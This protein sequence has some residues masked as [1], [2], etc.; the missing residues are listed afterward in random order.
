MHYSG[1]AALELDGRLRY[2]PL[3]FAASLL[4]A[5][6][7]ATMALALKFWL[8]RF[9]PNPDSIEPALL[10][11]LVLGGAISAM[12][13]LAM[14]ATWFLN[15][16][17]HMLKVAIQ[18]D[19][20]ALI[21]G[22]AV[23]LLLLFGGVFTAFGTRLINEY[24]QQ[25]AGARHL[26]A[27]VESSQD[28]IISMDLAGRVTSWNNGAKLLFGYSAE[29]M[30]GQNLT[31]LHSAET[32]GEEMQ[33]R[34]R[35]LNGEWVDHFETVRINQHSEPMAVSVTLS[36]IRDKLGT[37]VGIS[38]VL[39]D[40]RPLQR[41]QEKIRQN[42]QR[43]AYALEAS[44]DGIWDWYLTTHQAE[45]S[46][47]YYHLLGYEPDEFPAS[48][49]AWLATLHP[50][51]RDQI[52]AEQQCL[53]QQKNAFE[54]EFQMRA[55]NGSY[56]W[57]LSRGKVME[58]DKQG[59]PLRVVGTITDLTFRKQL[60][61][62]LQNSNQELSAIFNGVDVGIAYIH[63]RTVVRCNRKLEQLFGYEPGELVGKPT[64]CWHVNDTVYQQLGR[65]LRENIAEE[66]VFSGE[67]QLCRKDGSL[68]WVQVLGHALNPDNPDQGMLGVFRDITAERVA[69]VA[70]QAA[71]QETDA[72]NQ[73]LSSTANILTLAVRAADLGIWV[74][75]FDGD[76]IEWDERMI[77]LYAL[78]AEER[79]AGVTHPLWLSKVHPDD[80][81]SV[82]TALNEARRNGRQPFEKAFR[83]ALPDGR[84]RHI[85]SGSVVEFDAEGRPWRMVGVNRDITDQQE[86]Q[87]RLLAATREAQAANEAK[88]AFLANMSHEIRTPM[89][90]IIGLSALLK[91][92]ELTRQQREYLDKVQGASKALLNLINDILDYSKIEA[93]HLHFDKAPFRL[94]DAISNTK[95]LFALKLEEKGLAFKTALA[96]DLPPLLLGDSMRLEQVLNNLIGNAIKFTEQGEIGLQVD[97]LTLPQG[98][99]RLAKLRFT[100]RDTG[101]GVKPELLERLFQP[102][103]QADTTISRRFG[104]TGLGLSIAWRLVEL[105]GGEITVSSR[106]GHGSLFAFTVC[107]ECAESQESLPL[108]VK[109][110]QIATQS[111]AD[112][113]GA[114][115]LLAEDSMTNQIVAQ[116][117]LK[118]MQLRVT[119]AENGE[120]AIECAR[121][122]GFAAILMDIQMPIMD[123]YEATRQIRS[124]PTGRQL[125]I[126]ALSASAMAEDKQASL[127]AGM[128]DH[129]SKPID[130]DLLGQCLLKWVKPTAACLPDQTQAVTTSPID[131]KA[132]DYAL[133]QP[134]FLELEQCLV[135]NMLDAKKVAERI[136][137][138]LDHTSQATTFFVVSDQVR[139]MRFKEALS[140]LK[141]FK[142][143]FHDKDDS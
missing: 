126:I 142:Q 58:W 61:Q 18:P 125:P 96:P 84:I 15:D 141:A 39:S 6:L 98:N 112:I 4:V 13:Y 14:E 136:D 36:P 9:W 17:G 10:S 137:T 41:L 44:R 120:Q 131:S 135:E 127:N 72:A 23:F 59:Q 86:Q 99:Q 121:N 38:K 60:E 101:I 92:S 111:L 40:I 52:L 45:F 30:L 76:R 2:D 12:H 55:K 110:P 78:T 49:A 89:N 104:G 27:I 53:L 140:A 122:K 32:S 118:R 67:F 46:A 57:M 83:V 106:E 113:K 73:N 109:E 34:G 80:L 105:M 90:A 50:D 16:G 37:V 115:I 54:M 88:G 28:A 20:L 82:E 114:E 47:S 79:A 103:T 48:E 63:N 81:P 138:L 51:E 19:L 42:A 91:D 107:F 128:N 26:A 21:V 97:A 117:Y 3:W 1:M 24:R 70:L 5:V 33:L 85:I 132:L 119:L 68:F 124:L 102:F 130:F 7:L 56:K 11:G 62:S 139:K 134:L 100:V 123:G 31:R 87:T 65:D 95:S 43:Y 74:W 8:I 29:Q 133:L 22:L 129:L 71:K 66:S 94:E 116:G 143:T 35:V 77:E 64:R 25:E 108:L 75:Y 93:G 69:A